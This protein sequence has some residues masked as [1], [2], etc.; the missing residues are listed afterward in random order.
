MRQ[1]TIPGAP[2]PTN[3][4]LFLEW[5]R[6]AL[7]Q[8]Q[9]ASAENV[10]EPETLDV[11][12]K[13]ASPQFTGDPQAPT[14]DPGDSDDSIA[15]TAFVADAVASEASARDTAIGDAIAQE[16]LD[17]DQAIA[18]AAYSPPDIASPRILANI[19]GSTGPAS[20]EELTAIL[21]AIFGT[22]PDMYLR[23]GASAWEVGAAPT[24]SSGLI[25]VRS[26]NVTRTSTTFTNDAELKFAMSANKVYAVRLLIVT[27]PAT[28]GARLRVT[29]PTGVGGY[30]GTAGNMVPVTMS[31]AA[32]LLQVTDAA[33]SPIFTG[34]QGF[35]TTGGTAGDFQLQGALNTASGTMTVLKGSFIEYREIL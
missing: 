11:Y 24:S 17:R 6:E 18:D 32:D 8:I 22:T 27:T 4:P 29:G 16:V 25:V 28:G 13:I 34:F 23:R 30:L 31:T 1:I 2:P 12:A 14:P 10:F 19:S 33:A 21:D 26:A 7:H 9:L 15:T 35:V 3:D 5:V 20:A